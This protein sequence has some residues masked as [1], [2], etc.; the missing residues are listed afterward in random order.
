MFLFFSNGL[1]IILAMSFELISYLKAYFNK[2][3]NVSEILLHYWFL[4]GLSFIVLFAPFMATRHFL[5]VLPPI[6]LILGK[7]TFTYS[8]TLFKVAVIAISIFLSIMIGISDYSFAEYYK[9]NAKK[10]AKKYTRDRKIWFGGHWGWQWYARLAGMEQIGLKRL[11][12]VRAGDFIVLPEKIDK[13]KILDKLLVKTIGC[14]YE[15]RP[16][17]TF[18]STAGNARFYASTV[19]RVPWN[20]SKKPFG[21]IKIYEILAVKKVDAQSSLDQTLPTSDMN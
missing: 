20:F 8:K 17:Y 6:L 15:Q 21:T 12:E 10:I 13:G 2:R 18:F 5:L 14:V 7:S 4:S 19:K 3:A 1:F 11:S 16:W 9:D